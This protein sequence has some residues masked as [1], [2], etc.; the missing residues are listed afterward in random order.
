LIQT[1]DISFGTD[2]LCHEQNLENLKLSK[3]YNL[4]KVNTN[5]IVTPHV[6]GAT[7]ESQLKAL[8]TSI[9]LAKQSQ[10]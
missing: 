1:K 3:I 7:I 9:K 10:L 4:S 8:V 2:V 5:V 6:A